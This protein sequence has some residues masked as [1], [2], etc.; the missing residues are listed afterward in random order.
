[1]RTNSSAP[2][3]SNSPDLL[4]LPI[5]NSQSHGSGHNNTPLITLRTSL[6]RENV[7]I[8]SKSFILIGI[9]EG[10][11]MTVTLELEPELEQGLQAQARGVTVESFIQDLVSQ[12]VR[13]AVPPVATKR[14][15]TLPARNLGDMG[16]LH[17][18]DIYD[19]VR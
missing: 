2:I 12:L 10:Q 6:R 18:R 15:L 3:K 11:A 8:L 14:T 19:D 16:S 5:S 1:M 7:T 17:R 13:V 4:T 9:E